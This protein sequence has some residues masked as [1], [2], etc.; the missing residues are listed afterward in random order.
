MHDLEVFQK[1]ISD[2]QTFLTFC[3]ELVKG[4]HPFKNIVID[5]IDN[6]FKYCSQY[7]RAR[8]GIIHESDMEW[9]KGWAI[10]RDEF[11][12]VI[13]KLASLPYG[14]FMISHAELKEIKTRTEKY[15]KWMPTMPKQ[16]FEVIYPFCDIILFADME[17]TGEGEERIIRLRAGKYWEAGCRAKN[18]PEQ[19]P[20]DFNTFK[21]TYEGAVKQ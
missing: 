11:M 19:L 13:S 7:M 18:M 17:D 9:G 2:W 14:L 20:L 1:P 6:L 12:R 4:E 5:T 21:K 3:A 15:D 16:A 8:L 10:V